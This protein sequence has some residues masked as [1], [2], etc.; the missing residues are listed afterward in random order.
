M[1]NQLIVYKKPDNLV[2]D[3]VDDSNF[4]TVMEDSVCSS[5]GI[6][7]SESGTGTYNANY[8]NGDS[9]TPKI[10]GGIIRR[11]PVENINKRKKRKPHAKVKT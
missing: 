7:A 11:T 10:L 9:R 6:G 2:E 1:K 3:L 4:E 8:A 5:V